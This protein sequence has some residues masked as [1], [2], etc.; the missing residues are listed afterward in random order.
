MERLSCEDRRVVDLY[1]DRDQHE[2][3]DNR[4]RLRHAQGDLNA[5]GDDVTDLR[6]ML[7]KFEPNHDPLDPELSKEWDAIKEKVADMERVLGL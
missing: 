2:Y 7:A 3:E 1:L 6:K 5:L 4:R